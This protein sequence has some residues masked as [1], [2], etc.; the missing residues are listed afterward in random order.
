MIFFN[1][2][3][4]QGVARAGIEPHHR[5]MR[6]QQRNITDAANIQHRRSEIRIKKYRLMKGWHQG[7]ALSAESHIFTPEIPHNGDTGAGGKQIHI[8]D[9][10]AKGKL[11]VR[12]MP[13]RLSMATDSTNLLGRNLMGL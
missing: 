3:I 5:V 4:Q 8:A 2:L 1:P 11:A 13:Y 10:H 9:L 12:C 6:N 7:R